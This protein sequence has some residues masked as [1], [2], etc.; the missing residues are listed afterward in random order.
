MLTDCEETEGEPAVP[1]SGGPNGLVVCEPA[2]HPTED[3][4]L[5]VSGVGAG[6]AA[7]VIAR[8]RR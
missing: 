2:C 5:A 1:R 3:S 6:G 7:I 8:G 4:Y